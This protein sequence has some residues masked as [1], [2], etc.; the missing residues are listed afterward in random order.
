M[1]IVKKKRIHRR[2]LL[3]CAA[4]GLGTAIALPPL[5]A[6]FG[7]DSAYAAGA[8]G[9]PR[10]LAIYQPNGHH[11]EPFHPVVNGDIR[12]LSFAGKNSAPLEPWL[13]AGRATIL[14]NLVGPQAGYDDGI[15]KA[16][17]SSGNDHLVAI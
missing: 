8:Q 2:A 4:G 1:M 6:M 17:S 15:D 9:V 14:R 13:K 3:R 11:N 10:L 16:P 5:E 7:S 12:S